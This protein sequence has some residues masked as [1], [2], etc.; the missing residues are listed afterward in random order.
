M[1]SG[2]VCRVYLDG[3]FIGKTNEILQEISC[4]THKI[5]VRGEGI[6]IF[7]DTL[8]IKPNDLSTLVVASEN[9]STVAAFRGGRESFQQYIVEN[10]KYPEI[11]YK[12]RISGTVEIG[13]VIDSKGNVR[14][15]E[16]VNG[17]EKSLNRTAI[18]VVKL[19][20]NWIPATLNGKNVDSFVVIPIVFAVPQ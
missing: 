17:V 12:K 18:N 8:T 16:V 9:L 11:A 14:R 10:L 1:E 5:E 7:S 20:P 2:S 4:G 15:I 19:M 13:C 6:T 3:K